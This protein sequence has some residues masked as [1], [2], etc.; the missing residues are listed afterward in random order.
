M[1]NIRVFT[2]KTPEITASWS[3]KQKKGQLAL[4]EEKQHSI[5]LHSLDLATRNLALLLEEVP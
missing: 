1:H 4:L 3:H 2:S 5:G